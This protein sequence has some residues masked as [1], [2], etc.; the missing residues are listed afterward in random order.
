MR[1]LRSAALYFI[2]VFAVGF[3][4]GPI[5]VLWLEPRLGPTLAAL[6]EAPFLL[7]AMAVAARWVTR[8]TELPRKMWTLAAMGLGA[9]LL[10]QVADFAV[11]LGLRGMSPREQ[12]AAFATPAGVIYVVLLLAFVAMP[13]LINRKVVARRE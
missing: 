9:L 5:R 1:I 7:L 10:Q 12:F 6:C 4:L 11:G 2:I 8:K 13:L 3:L